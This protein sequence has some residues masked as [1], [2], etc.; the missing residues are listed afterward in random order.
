MVFEGP[1][2]DAVAHYAHLIG[3]EAR[4]SRDLREWWNRSGTQRARI[5]HGSVEWLGHGNGLG[6]IVMGDT[7]VIRFE[8][9]R[10]ADVMACDLRFSCVVSTT[11]GI[12]VLHFSNEDDHFIFPDVERCLATIRKAGGDN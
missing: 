11:T 9:V 4:V 7:L 10:E 2:V 8:V 6:H 3:S 5:V 12:P 1:A